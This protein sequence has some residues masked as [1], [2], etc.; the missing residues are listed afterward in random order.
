[1]NEYM[2]SNDDINTSI[3][4]TILMIRLIAMAMVMMI[5]DNG[6]DHEENQDSCFN[7]HTIKTKTKVSSI[8]MHACVYESDID[9]DKGKGR[10]GKGRE[11]RGIFEKREKIND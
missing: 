8:S 3:V 1:M 5:I 6:Y 11:G 4:I 2:N 10:E 7:K 9:D